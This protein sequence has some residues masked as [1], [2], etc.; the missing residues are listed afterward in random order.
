MLTGLF[1]LTM[2]MVKDKL[3]RSYRAFL[4]VLGFLRLTVL[5][6]FESTLV[7]NRVFLKVKV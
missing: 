7:L 1:L 3:S 6:L 4:L 5:V 2:G